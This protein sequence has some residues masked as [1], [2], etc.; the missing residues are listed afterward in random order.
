MQ[1]HEDTRIAYHCAQ[2]Q[3]SLHSCPGCDNNIV[4]LHGASS[5][6]IRAMPV[7]NTKKIVYLSIL[8]FTGSFGQFQS[9]GD[10]LGSTWNGPILLRHNSTQRSKELKKRR[11]DE[12]D[13]NEFVSTELATFGIGD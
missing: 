5:Y 10:G 6:C 12:T 2:R 13:N 3:L 1:L 8:T 9:K 11:I 7:N 4:Y